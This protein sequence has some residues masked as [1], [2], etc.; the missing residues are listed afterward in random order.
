M[1]VLERTIE[2]VEERLAY[3]SQIYIRDDIANYEFTPGDID[4]PNAL[5]KGQ[6]RFYFIHCSFH[7]VQ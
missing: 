4:Y 7:A 5:L 3:R 1:P 6:T 2:D